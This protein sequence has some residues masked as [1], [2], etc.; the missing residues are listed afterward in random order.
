[1]AVVPLFLALICC[2]AKG[3][4]TLS[5]VRASA[6]ETR[7]EASGNVAAM[8]FTVAQDG[9]ETQVESENQTRDGNGTDIPAAADPAAKERKL[10]KHAD[11][12]IEAD[13]SLLDGEGRL[14]GV[15]RKLDELLKPYGAYSEETRIQDDSAYF[16]IRVPQGSYDSFLSGIGVLGK[17]RSRIE[18]VEDVTLQYYDLEGR[19]NTKKTLLATFQGY[20]SRA[21][22]IDDIMKVETRIA[23]LQ[24][25][26]DWLGTQLTQ[27]AGLVDYATVE[28]TVYNYHSYTGYTLGDRLK[29]LFA[30]FGDFASGGLVVLVGIIIFGI[31]LV[32]LCLLAFWLFFGRLGILKKAF[33]LALYGRNKKE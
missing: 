19:L 7:Y 23:D 21:R 26:I 27:L 15:N 9:R 33:R 6:D 30:S 28:L 29:D 1:L 17:I 31:P 24:N 11:I 13:K 16:K 18:R 8:G 5:E 22:D 10:V 3:S 32:L 12:A 14:T 20:L 25:E 2:G 4:A